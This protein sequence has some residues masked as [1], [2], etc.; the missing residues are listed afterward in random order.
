MWFW[1]ILYIATDVSEE[2]AAS[3]FGINSSVLK[4]GPCIFLRKRSSRLQGVTSQK[5]VFFSQNLKSRLVV[6][7]P[8]LTNCHSNTALVY[9]NAL[10]W[11][12]LHTATS[13][14]QYVNTLSRH[15][16]FLYVRSVNTWNRNIPIGQRNRRNLVVIC[17]R[18]IRFESTAILNSANVQP[19]VFWCLYVEEYK[20]QLLLLVNI[21][22]S[23]KRLF[24]GT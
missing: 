23:L 22:V 1:V 11:G 24:V 10:Q 6:I 14:P 17:I 21:V 13:F 18:H 9:C 15:R 2:R 7:L 3:T 16:Y 12:I 19:L 8:V 5:A 20:P 4:D